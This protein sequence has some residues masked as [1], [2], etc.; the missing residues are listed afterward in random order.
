MSKKEVFVTIKK[1]G[2]EPHW[3]YGAGMT[4]LSCVLCI[5]ASKNDL[6]IAACLNPLL[7]AMYVALE[8]EVGKTMMMP[9][10]GVT[11]TLE[12]ITEIKADLS[13]LEEQPAVKPISISKNKLKLQQ[14]QMTSLN[15]E[16]Q[17]DQY[18]GITTGSARHTSGLCCR[19]CS[20]YK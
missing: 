5:M 6:T 11:K 19:S 12:E 13:L 4:R 18:C 1:A 3:V 20:H 2:Q 17:H 8:M 15:W 9:I 16:M 10:K 14:Q 7:Y